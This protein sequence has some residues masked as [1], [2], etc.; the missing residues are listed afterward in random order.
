MDLNA[1]HYPDKAGAV[2]G[3]W[4]PD[5][6]DDNPTLLTGRQR[7]TQQWQLS[8]G[9]S[10]QIS[11]P[12]ACRCEAMEGVGNGTPQSH[13]GMS[14]SGSVIASYEYDSP[15]PSEPC[16]IKANDMLGH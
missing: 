3:Q 13:N 9:P 11:V 2:A 14:S 12:L 16:T 6:L 10:R 7:Q 1:A 15:C 8:D 5:W 4:P